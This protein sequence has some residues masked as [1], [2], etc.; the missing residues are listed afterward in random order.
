MDAKSNMDRAK[1]DELKD[2]ITKF[3]VDTFKNELPLSDNEIEFIVLLY[4]DEKIDGERAEF[5]LNRFLNEM[6]S[7]ENLDGC[8]CN[9]IYLDGS[10]SLTELSADLEVYRK[11]L[12]EAEMTETMQDH[13]TKNI[14]YWSTLLTLPAFRDPFIKFVK[15]VEQKPSTGW[16]SDKVEVNLTEALSKLGVAPELVQDELRKLLFAKK[17]YITEDAAIGAQMSDSLTNEASANG[18]GFWLRN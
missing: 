3:M 17:A 5:N 6:A 11:F 7:S 2:K 15:D 16:A 10:L 9:M 14:A 13:L 4:E 18:I 8:F 12:R 1:R